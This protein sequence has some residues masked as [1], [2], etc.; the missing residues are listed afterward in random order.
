MEKLFEIRF[1]AKPERLCL[2]R[3]L[4]KETTE[5]IGCG[6]DLTESIIN[7]FNSFT[8]IPIKIRII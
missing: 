8:I 5:N 4:V 2:V 1:L 3:A 7:F 6:K